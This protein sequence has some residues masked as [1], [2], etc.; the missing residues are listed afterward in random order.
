MQQNDSLPLSIFWR[1]RGFECGIYVT[2]FTLH[3]SHMLSYLTVFFW[4]SYVL[5]HRIFQ[6]EV[7]VA[8]ELY[9]NVLRMQEKIEKCGRWLHASNLICIFLFVINDT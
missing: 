7:R 1:G 8:Q 3:F 2:F 5:K 4:L 9:Y 6:E